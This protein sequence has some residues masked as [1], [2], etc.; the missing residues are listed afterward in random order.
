MYIS[1]PTTYDDYLSYYKNQAGFGSLHPGI[2][3]YRGP[4]YQRGNGVGSWFT[5]AFKTI[6]PI[7]KTAGKSLLKEGLNFGQD[8]Y[9]GENVVDSLKHRLA[10]AGGDILSQVADTVRGRT[11]TGSGRR[12]KRVAGPSKRKTQAKRR[13]TV[14]KRKRKTVKRK[15]GSTKKKRS[16]T[17]RKTAKSKRRR[18]PVATSIFD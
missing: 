8:L 13:K 16:T 4:V 11:Q 6:T 14:G 5:N 17:K 10:E 9:R 15:R 3:S 18:K 12:R 7:F 1:A 2:T